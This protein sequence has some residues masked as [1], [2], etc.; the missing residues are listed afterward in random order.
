MESINGA[1]SRRCIIQHPTESL[2]ELKRIAKQDGLLIID[3]EH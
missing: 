1:T 3:D 2:A